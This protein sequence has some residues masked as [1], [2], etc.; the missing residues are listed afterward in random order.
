MND[1]SIDLYPHTFRWL[2]LSRQRVNRNCVFG[3]CRRL[4]KIIREIL[5]Y[6][7]IFLV[8]LDDTNTFNAN[9][10]FLLELRVAFAQRRSCLRRVLFS[11]SE[12][13]V[14]LRDIVSMSISLIGKISRK[15]SQ[16][17][18]KRKWRDRRKI[19]FHFVGESEVPR[20]QKNISNWID[21]CVYT[22]WSVSFAFSCNLR[23]IE[24]W[25]NQ[26]TGSLFNFRSKS[27]Q[28]ANYGNGRFKF[29]G[30]VRFW[31]VWSCSR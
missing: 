11:F 27:K 31:S 30:S 5:S 23:A 26:I 13:V 22:S 18:K 12:K 2:L 29:V 4:T 6:K 19:F 9:F 1:L 10:S 16:E 14:I 7:K 8:R 20:K 21:S 3:R 25:H 17:R 24:R 28:E 15:I